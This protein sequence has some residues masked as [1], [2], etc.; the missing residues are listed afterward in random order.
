MCGNSENKPSKFQGISETKILHFSQFY[1]FL[2]SVK[3]RKLMGDDLTWNFPFVTLLLSLFH[4]T[5]TVTNYK[6]E[7]EKTLRNT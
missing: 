3:L 1:M 7:S 6:W 2:S 5:L 4:L